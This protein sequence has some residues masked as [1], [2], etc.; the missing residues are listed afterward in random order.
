MDLQFDRNLIL[1]VLKKKSKS[2]GSFRSDDSLRLP[3]A[4]PCLS[5]L[6][7]ARKTWAFSILIKPD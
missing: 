7:A 2:C 3:V 4:F 6:L 1:L 5:A